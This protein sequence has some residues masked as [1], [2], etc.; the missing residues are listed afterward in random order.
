M[1]YL[2]RLRSRNKNENTLHG[3]RGYFRMR[4]EKGFT[5]VELM[6]VVSIVA[7]LAAVATPAY[8]NYVN[9]TKQGR[10][11]SLLLTARLEME[12][13]YTDFGQYAGT[14][15]CLPSFAGAN[16]QCLSNCVAAGCA[17]SATVG[18]YVFS[19]PAIVQGNGT[20]VPYYRVAAMK[21][22]NAGTDQ[23]TISS[24]TDTPV[25]VNPGA[26]KFSVF[27]WLFN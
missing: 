14:I 27:Q 9:R 17:N 5:L 3:K 26:L 8:I 16:T 1:E 23:L 25:I 21:A 10:A 4:G 6:V 24:N 2:G 19:V 20:T 18:D 13:R 15:K 7:V 22:V 11:V 12:E